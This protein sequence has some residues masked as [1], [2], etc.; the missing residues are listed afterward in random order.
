MTDDTE[1]QR[2]E[3]TVR[4][5]GQRLHELTLDYQRDHPDANYAAALRAVCSRPE[6]LPV[7]L[8]YAARARRGRP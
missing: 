7:V 6:N 8:A 2:I 1:D 3:L 5:A 4:E